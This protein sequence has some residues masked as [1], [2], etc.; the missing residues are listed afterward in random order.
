MITQGKWLVEKM[1]VSDGYNIKDE[2]GAVLFQSWGG[3]KKYAKQ[4]KDNSNLIAA[5]PELLAVCKAISNLTHQINAEQ[6]AGLKVTGEQWSKLYDLTFEAKAVI[7][8]A[9]GKE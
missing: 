8:Q 3:N 9:E 5:A 6:H 4:Q 7:A 2:T 1:P